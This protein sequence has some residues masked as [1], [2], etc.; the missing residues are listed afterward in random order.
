MYAR[1]SQKSLAQKSMI[2]NIEKFIDR[3]TT[4]GII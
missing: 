3:K 4:G 1:I 2:S